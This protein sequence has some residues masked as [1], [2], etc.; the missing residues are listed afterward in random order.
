MSPKS[1]RYVVLP[2]PKAVLVT[3]ASGGIGRAICGAFGH[4]GW[5]VGVHY[6]CNKI[7]ADRILRQVVRDGGAGALFEA[8][9]RNPQSVQ[10]M[11]VNFCRLVAVPSVFVCAA[12]IGSG[13]LLL[14]QS[15]EEWTNVIATNLTG[16][17]SCLRAMAAPLLEHGGGSI[18]VVGSYAGFHG[19]IGQAAYAASKSGLIG[20]VKTAAKEWGSRNVRVN[21]VLP[22]WHKTR[23]SKGA[24][25]G[26]VGWD[27]H[28]LHRPPSMDEV[29]QTVLYLAQ[30]KDVSGQVW[31]CDSRDL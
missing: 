22:G 9:I 26:D 4:A 10:S 27:D 24:L 3:G 13:R 8:D 16:T 18:I 17:F 20:L 12:G 21:L 2:S 25:P 19:T 7:D 5:F 29:S 15:L 23:M 11:V 14:K 28:A 1:A 30:L 31:N 6:H